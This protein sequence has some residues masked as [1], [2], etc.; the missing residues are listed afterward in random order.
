MAMLNKRLHSLLSGEKVNC[1]VCK[2]GEY[3]AYTPNLPLKEQTYFVCNN[4][5]YMLHLLQKSK[6][7]KI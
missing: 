1:D 6:R 7:I 2:I 4:C 3:K 5:G